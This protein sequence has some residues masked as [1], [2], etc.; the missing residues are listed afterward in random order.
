MLK[1]FTPVIVFFFLLSHIIFPA[2]AKGSGVIRGT[3]TKVSDGDTIVVRPFSGKLFKCR[4]YGIDAPEIPHN[5]K[6]GQPYGRAADRELNNLVLHTTVDVVLTGDRSYDR[7]ICM[8]NKMGLD[9]NREMVR[10]GYAW[11]YRQYLR[12]PYASEYMEAEN[13]ARKMRRGLWQQENPTP[14]W[15]FRKRQFQHL[16]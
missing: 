5:G 7:E 1:K 8:I 4:L 12:R 9:I 15:E 3:V 6:P 13:E 10:R 14:P 11:A 16:Q 2:Y